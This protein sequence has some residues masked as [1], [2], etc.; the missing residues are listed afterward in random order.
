MSF[1]RLLA[2]RTKNISASALRELLKVSGQPG[3]ISLSGGY[4]APDSFPVDIM[5]TLMD[6]VFEKYGTT[7]LQYGT[8]EGFNPLRE[9]LVSY[10]ARRGIKAKM[11]DIYISSGSQ[12]FLDAVGKILINK[13]DCVAVEAPTYLGALQAFNAYEPQYIRLE[14]DDEGVIPESVEETL[15]SHLIKFI[16]LVP[17][18]QNPTGRT[19]GLER[20]KRIAA[21]IQAHDALAVEDDPY[22]ELRYRGERIPTLKSLAPD[23]VIYASTLSKVFAPGFRVGF[24]IAPESLRTWLIRVKQGVDLNTSTFTQA[25]AAEYIANGFLEKQI[26]K[27][28]EIYRPKQEAMLGALEAHLTG[29]FKWIKPD[30]GMFIW[31]IGPKGMDMEAYYHKAVEKKVAFV[32]GKFFFTQKGE[33]LETMR[34]NYTSPDITS[35]EKGVKILSEVLK[36]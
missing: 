29:E 26:P 36:A 15:K 34:L 32:P 30:G 21:I 7:A 25:L 35:I 20:R 12:G 31:V 16:Y 27:I 8:T 19:M 2:P 9:A 6:K 1:D 5:D 24:Y 17:T 33:G 28:V 3:M 11:D 4:P 14:M 18:F 10:V 13:G 23:H 22:S